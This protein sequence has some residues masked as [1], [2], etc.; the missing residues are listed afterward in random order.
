MSHQSCVEEDM[1]VDHLA[2][3]LPER[4]EAEVQCS[5]PPHSFCL[6]QGSYRLLYYSYSVNLD[7]CLTMK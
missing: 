4:G 6:L 5:V 3:M 1:L 7:E 2:P